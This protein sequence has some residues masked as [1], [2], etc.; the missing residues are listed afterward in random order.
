MT[1]SLFGLY[2]TSGEVDGHVLAA[3]TEV[4][5]QQRYERREELAELVRRHVVG[6]DRDQRPEATL[7]VSVEEYRDVEQ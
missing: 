6:R 3:H 5:K 4:S 7:V 1:A 2:Q